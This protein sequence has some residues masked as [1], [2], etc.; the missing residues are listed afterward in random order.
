MDGVQRGSGF[1]G[2]DLAFY[3][4]T[5]EPFSGSA[6]GACSLRF[7]HRC[8]SIRLTISCH[9]AAAVVVG[10]IIDGGWFM[11]CPR[12]FFVLHFSIL[13]SWPFGVGL[14]L[15]P[16]RCGRLFANRGLGLGLGF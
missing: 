10:H 6:T 3:G 13:A 16:I 15:G 12:V 7:R 11:G 2:L 4:K 8:D 9:G 5:V 14:G 1:R